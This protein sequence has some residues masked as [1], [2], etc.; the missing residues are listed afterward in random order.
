MLK[1]FK[2]A[3]YGLL[4]VNLIGC[5]TPVGIEPSEFEPILVVEGFINDDYG[6][7]PF[8]I[9][10]LARFAGVTDGGVIQRVDNAT[11]NIYDDLGNVV[12][13]SRKSVIRKEVFNDGAPFCVPAVAFVSVQTD[14]MTPT[15]FKGEIGRTYTLEIIIDSQTYRSEP[16]KISPTPPIEDLSLSFVE[17]PGNDPQNPN[18]G[19]EIAATWDDP[20]GEDFYRWRMNG[21]YRIS[22]PDIS[23]PN[24]SAC[25][26]F[27]P[28]DNGVSDCWIQERGLSG[29]V[30]ALSDRFFD[31]TRVTEKVGFVLD[32]GLRFASVEVPASKQYY[33]EIEQYRVSLEAFDFLERVDIL[34]TIDGE[35]FDPPP[36]SIRGN[37]FN[38]MNPDEQ[39][40]GFFGAYDVQKR[41]IFISRG[42]LGFIQR[43]PRVCGDCR[44]RPGAQTEV[45]DPFK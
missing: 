39:V 34:A 5:I 41:S 20:L 36:V 32:D 35:I 44:V 4:L 40:I 2:I 38:I 17:V 7:H 29:N 10:R 37:I 15:D 25:C 24:S 23:G 8:K 43:F 12:N 33:V 30:R 1:N 45:P 6:P 13:L 3:L 21:I 42:D 26:I 31:G 14:F 27:D 16:Q 28:R 19:V 9:T 22:T 11:V 18:S